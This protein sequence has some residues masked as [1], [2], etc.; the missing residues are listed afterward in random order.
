MTTNRDRRRRGATQRAQSDKRQD[1][2][3]RRRADMHAAEGHAGSIP[4]GNQPTEYE[5]VGNRRGE[6]ERL[7][8]H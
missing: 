1:Q 5:N 3:D 6:W 4:R 8:G 2:L 7:L